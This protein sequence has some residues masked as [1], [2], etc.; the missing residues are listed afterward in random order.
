MS[1][2]LRG[3]LLMMLAMA[4]FRVNE[5]CT[6]LMA[7][8]MPLAQIITLRGLVITGG[9]FLI[10]WRMRLL[11]LRLTPRLWAMLTVRVGA[12]VGAAW[13]YLQALF[14]MPLANVTAIAQS[15]PLLL[16][17]AAAVFLREPLGWRRLSAIM[18]GLF[19]VLI[20]AR[21]G[22]DGF[23]AFAIY[24]LISVVIGLVRDLVTRSMPATVSTVTVALLTV[25]GVTLAFAIGGLFDGQAWVSVSGRD[26]ALLGTAGVASL[27][28][29]LGSI[30]AM[31]TGE[32]AF[33]SAFRYTG[34]IWALV[35]GLLV[36]G[37]WPGWITLAGAGIVVA[38]GLFTI[39]RERQLG[40][41]KV[42]A[43]AQN[44]PPH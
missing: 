34:L 40:L 11:A 15:A 25:G 23:D 43:S 33:V 30:T 10:A 31:R 28:A 7:G 4:L 13:F 38:S 35:I 36:F 21:P 20:I 2:N 1:D 12:E 16:S 19:G 8:E 29:F 24:A 37:D 44:R 32:I 3:A 6:K 18:L 27:F 26:M 22:P 39:Y 14:N 9:T 41:G 17:L 42:T 5:T